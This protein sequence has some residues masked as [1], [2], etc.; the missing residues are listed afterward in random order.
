MSYDK[1]NIFAKIL[2]GEVASK[3]LYED[4]Y[5]V[6]ISDIAPVSPVHVLVMPKGEYVSF[7]DFSARAP[8]EVIAGF[9]KAVRMVARLMRVETSG[10]RL[11]TNHGMDASQSVP[12]FHVHLLGGRPLGGLVAGD[13]LNR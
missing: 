1:S 2:R 3:K 6:A 12:H 9:F 8:A 7:D 4:E 5:A 10:Y 13:P 11:I